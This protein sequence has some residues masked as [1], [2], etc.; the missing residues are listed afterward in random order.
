[1]LRNANDW[2][3]FTM[4][5]CIAIFFIL[6]SFYLSIR[7]LDIF[8]N[9]IP[10]EN[11]LITLKQEIDIIELIS[12]FTIFGGVLAYIFKVV[13]QRELEDEN[14]GLMC[15]RKKTYVLE[16]VNYILNRTMNHQEHSS[17]WRDSTAEE[18]YKVFGK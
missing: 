2:V 16:N 14:R 6:S 1:M 15:M 18:V 12:L 10:L 8:G 11:K 5:F 7:I 17:N 4:R 9:F 13:V 3:I